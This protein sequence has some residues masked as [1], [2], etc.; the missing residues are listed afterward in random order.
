MESS[1][2]LA[3]I[4][5]DRDGAVSTLHGATPAELRNL[6]DAATELA[7]LCREMLPSGKDYR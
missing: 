1:A 4:E 6:R 3:L 5:D 2:L 7:D